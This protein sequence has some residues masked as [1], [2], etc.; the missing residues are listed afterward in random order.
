MRT[1]EWIGL[2]DLIAVEKLKIRQGDNKMLKRFSNEE[3]AFKGIEALDRVM[4]RMMKAD[5]ETGFLPFTQTACQIGKNILM[6]IEDD[7]TGI[8]V[9]NS[10]RFIVGSWVL[11]RFAD[12]GLIKLNNQRSNRDP[13]T[14]SIVD[15]DAVIR[16][17][18]AC[19]LYTSPSPRDAT[20]SRMP[21]SA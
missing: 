1:T 7:S 17:T 21:S 15:I 11:D 19:L 16:L 5:D 10:R 2:T 18:I 8:K 4:N 13:L 9:I 6:P 3:I 20:L 14:I 12:L